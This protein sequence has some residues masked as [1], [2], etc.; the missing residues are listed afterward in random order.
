MNAT[1]LGLNI[2]I[3]DVAGDLPLGLVT[4]GADQGTVVL[5]SVGAVT[6]SD[7]LGTADIVGG[8]VTVNALKGHGIGE[9]DAIETNVTSITASNTPDPDV[10]SDDPIRITEVAVGDGLIVNGVTQGDVGVDT[11]NKGNIEILTQDGTLTIAGAVIARDGGTITLTAG[12]V[13]L[14]ESHDVVINALITSQV[15]LKDQGL[16]QVTPGKVTVLADTDVLFDAAAGAILVQQN[17]IDNTDQA[18]KWVVVGEAE[19]TATNGDILETDNN[20]D[21]DPEISAGTITLT[22]GNGAIGQGTGVLPLTG[23]L[24]V[25][26]SISLDAT[27]KYDINLADALGDFNIGTVES[28]DRDSVTL[29]ALDGGIEE[30]G[31]DVAADVLGGEVSLIAMDGGIGENGTLEIESGSLTADSSTASGDIDIKEV[32]AGVDLLLGHNTA[33][34]AVNAGTGDVQLESAGGAIVDNVAGETTAVISADDVT[35]LAVNGIGDTDA[36]GATTAIETTISTIDALNTTTG[37]IDIVELAD[38]ETDSA[39]LETDLIVK[40]ATQTNDVG[41][42]SIVTTDGT[43]KVV[44]NGVSVPGTSAGTITLDANGAADTDDEDLVILAPI[45]SGTGAVNLTADNDVIFRAGGDVSSVDGLVTITADADGDSVADEGEVVMDDGAVV[46][47]GVGRIVVDAADNVELGSL[48]TTNASTVP[49]TPAV[50]INS[51]TGAVTDGGDTD[52]DI[53]ANVGLVDINAVKGV[54]SNNAIETTVKTLDVLNHTLGA[55]PATGNIRISET[56]DII[57]NQLRTQN[58]DDDDPLTGVIEL[59]AGGTITIAAAGTGV[60]TK[61]GNIAIDANGPTSSVVINQAVTV[62]EDSTVDVGDVMITAD[63]DVVFSV[64]GDV[65]TG[66]GDAAVGGGNIDIQA[67]ADEIG[68]G[69]SGAIAM[70]DSGA[71]STV[72]SSE[73]GWI[74]LR[75]DE[76]ISLGRLVTVNDTVQAVRIASTNADLVDLGDS[77]GVD[78]EA[79]EPNAVTTI[80][81]ATGVGAVGPGNDIDTHIANVDIDNT[82]NGDVQLIELDDIGIIRIVQASPT[83]S[84]FGDIRVQTIDGTITVLPDVADEVTEPV[85][86]AT[87]TGE[88]VLDANGQNSD[89]ILNEA[90]TTEDGDVTLT[91][92]DHIEFMIEG[93]VIVTGAGNVSVTSNEDA[94]DEV[95]V[96][97]ATHDGDDNDDILMWNG[98]VIQVGTGLQVT[99][100]GKIMLRSTGD[101]SGSVTVGSLQTGNQADDAVLIRTDHDV[102]DAA[103]QE[104]ALDGDVD[105]VAPR[106]GLTVVSGTGTSLD[107]T[108]STLTVTNAVNDDVDIDETDNLSIL[109]V[110]QTQTG[111][112]KVTAGG[113]MT[114]VRAGQGVH[115]DGATAND[116]SIYLFAEQGDLVVEQAITNTSTGADADIKLVAAGAESDVIIGHDITAEGGNIIALADY[117]VRQQKDSAGVDHGILATHGGV[118]LRAGDDVFVRRVEARANTILFDEVKALIPESDRDTFGIDTDGDGETDAFYQNFLE[119][120]DPGPEDIDSDQLDDDIISAVAIKIFATD[121]VRVESTGVGQPSLKAVPNLPGGATDSKVV[122]AAGAPNDNTVAE[123]NIAIDPKNVV[124]E[125]EGQAT[126]DILIQANEN[127]LVLN[128]DV[129]GEI[130]TAD[131][132]DDLAGDLLIMADVDGN[133]TGDLDLYNAV[134]AQN[135]LLGGHDVTTYVNGVVVADGD[136]VINAGGTFTQGGDVTAGDQVAAIAEDKDIIIKSDTV[137]THLAYTSGMDVVVM[138]GADITLTGDTDYDTLFVQIEGNFVKEPYTTIDAASPNATAIKAGK[139]AVNVKA[140]NIVLADLQATDAGGKV[141]LEATGGS[142]TLAAVLPGVAWAEA[143]ITADVVELRATDGVGVNP[144]IGV[145]GVEK[146]ADGNNT[147]LVGGGID[148][149]PAG[150]A[151]ALRIYGAETILAKT[152]GDG[153][154]IDIA[155]VNAE[156]V[157]VTAQTLGEDANILFGQSGGGNL[158]LT[159]VTTQ[160]GDVGVTA[161]GKVTANKVWARDFAGGDDL[162]GDGF[163][164]DNGING[165]VNDAHSV[166]ITTNATDASITVVDVRADYN[167]TFKTLGGGDVIMGDNAIQAGND[168]DVELVQ[169]GDIVLGSNA[170]T[171]EGDVLLTSRVGSILDGSASDDPNVIA[172]NDVTLWVGNRIGDANTPE[173]VVVHAGGKLAVGAFDNAPNFANRYEDMIWAYLKGSSGDGSIQYVYTNAD[174]TP[175]VELLDT[176]PGVIEWNMRAWGGPETVVRNI[177]NVEELFRGLLDLTP[178]YEKHLYNFGH[179][180]FPHVWSM[181]NF[182]PGSMSIEFILD[183]KGKIE[184]LPE[185]FGPTEIDMNAL[186]DTF[187]YNF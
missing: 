55:D 53:V 150:V 42:I 117:D 163:P 144:F 179:L 102:F 24:E 1:A 75:A 134:S 33:A 14:D 7:T 159:D 173:D 172:G 50:S 176:P 156:D 158:V 124:I 100:P 89:L 147:A 12:D 26:N 130:L 169:D 57:V 23:A 127:I 51:D 95:G 46:D 69:S 86:V 161:A 79:N 56:D 74:R 40:N 153:G 60:E 90:V 180:Y 20:P 174:T 118:L 164:D 63:H 17:L 71:D 4:G 91:A 34:I 44:E 67:D 125:G 182:V 178:D 78:I 30:F 70:A 48:Q 77:L 28:T 107:T 49:G 76:R 85:V 108:I 9:A 109:E 142:I 68:D 97:N 15:D 13:G 110:E 123:L 141:K 171:A 185:G 58:A 84:N 151:T 35:L 120:G 32:T 52:I 126:G 43:L 162:D 87:A 29:T 170:I 155:S 73:D 167:G 101:Y 5:Q 83:Q 148:E 181:I 18:P 183:G 47:A 149:D 106:G 62:L 133:G 121:L 115:I 25:A 96:N 39:G 129:V 72:V 61:D 112:I 175:G 187:S 105:V 177:Y 92:D 11:I 165:I 16:G 27:A 103:D 137:A 186:G 22:A 8:A 64:D 2:A 122:E 154:D 135:I 19:V 3:D 31:D 136:V 36:I 104:A 45:N 184:G 66:V 113:S 6:D 81:T 119:P 128:E 140:A 38:T 152:S 82:V 41:N 143:G 116:D 88:V 98:A 99:S 94:W 168:V 59:T 93:D 146:D 132:D 21:V 54:G 166:L 65:S 157:A 160:H 80:D 111:S 131:V 139:V 138:E 37:N 10:W 114:V 145:T